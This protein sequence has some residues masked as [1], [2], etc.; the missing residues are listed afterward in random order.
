MK[1][2]PETSADQSEALPVFGRRP[3][4]LDEVCEFMQ[5]SPEAIRRFRFRRIDPLPYLMSG[6]RLNFDE[7]EVR[8]WMRRNAKRDYKK[9]GV[10]P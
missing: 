5:V 1:T 7:G 9:K 6:R 3:M 4:T 2:I 10:L 8:R